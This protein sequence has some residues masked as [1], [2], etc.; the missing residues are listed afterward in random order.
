MATIQGYGLSVDVPDG[1]EGRVFREADPEEDDGRPTMHVGNFAMPTDDATYGSSI[2]KSMTSGG[3]MYMVLAEYTPD[4]LLPNTGATVPDDPATVDITQVGA[5]AFGNPGVP[6]LQV[7]DFF[8]DV[9]H[10]TTSLPNATAV[11]IPFT[12]AGRLF[13]LYAV[14][15]D[16]SGLSTAVAS[17]NDVLA[18]L[19]VSPVLLCSFDMRVHTE[20]ITFNSPFDPRHSAHSGP[21]TGSGTVNCVFARGVERTV[22]VH[23]GGVITLTGTYTADRSI[24]PMTIDGV[25][26]VEL[27]PGLGVDPTHAQIADVSGSFGVDWSFTMP[28]FLLPNVAA[29]G[30]KNDPIPLPAIV[31]QPSSLSNEIRVLGCL[32]AQA[33]SVDQTILLPIDTP[34]VSASNTTAIPVVWR[35]DRPA[36]GALAMTAFPTVSA[37]RARSHRVQ[38]G[39]ASFHLDPHERRAVKVRLNRHGRAMLARREHLRVDLTVIAESGKQRIRADK[40]V[41]L[42]RKRRHE[43][44][45]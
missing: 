40:T 6:V 13:V 2:I 23:R 11:Q 37:A 4:C 20:V 39:H 19:L 28:T 18:T 31:E 3:Q 45:H 22:T 10:G 8:R 43:A 35:G 12:T 34:A 38:V 1:W 27:V 21:I 14:V 44:H 41:L 7:P 26:D 15:G 9:V 5:V 25:L 24:D 17:L 29:Q 42:K 32:V 30:A 33:N 36:Q 16:D